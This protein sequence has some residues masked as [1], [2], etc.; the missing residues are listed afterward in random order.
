MQNPSPSDD[1]QIFSI[2]GAKALKMASE[3]FAL[4][5]GHVICLRRIKV[6]ISKH[7]PRQFR[8]SVCLFL[9]VCVCG[10]NRKRYDRE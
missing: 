5:P 3:I 10:K 8:I 9:D 2:L 4:L 6:G 7:V 1:K